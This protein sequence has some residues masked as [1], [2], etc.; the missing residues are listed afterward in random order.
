MTNKSQ[1]FAQLLVTSSLPEEVKEMIIKNIKK[2][3]NDKLEEIYNLLQEEEQ[4]KQKA[5]LQM[6]LEVGQVV[7]EIKRKSEEE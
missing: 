2:I 7:E 5:I 1:Q 4:E 6:D 3:P